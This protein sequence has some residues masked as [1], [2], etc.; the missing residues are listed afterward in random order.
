[1]L[2]TRS[3]GPSN[4]TGD[5]PT[6][7]S[8]GPEPGTQP[9]TLK[10]MSGIQA[11]VHLPMLQKHARRGGGAEHRRLHLRLPRLAARQSR[12]GAVEGEEAPDRAQDPLPARHQRGTRRNR[13]LGHAAGQPVRRRR[14]RWRVR[15]V[16]WQGAGRRPQRRRVQARQR[17]RHGAAGRRAGGGRRRSR[18]QVLDPA[19]P[20]RPY[21]HRGDDARS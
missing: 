1:M 18:R 7:N 16:V 2:D 9:D 4:P 21:L 8:R 3:A 14:S 5:E 11:L 20:E 13:G 10:Y 12:P 17:R 6:G 19:A 15:H